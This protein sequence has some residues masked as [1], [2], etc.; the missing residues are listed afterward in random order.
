[1]HDLQLGE[2]DALEPL[3]YHP[4]LQITRDPV[5]IS[6]TFVPTGMGRTGTAGRQGHSG[7][8]QARAPEWHLDILSG[9]SP[10]PATCFI[11][12]TSSL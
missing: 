3:S 6:L 12:V 10:T 1:M 9:L 5:Q 7:T 2:T 8:T 11:L 4:G